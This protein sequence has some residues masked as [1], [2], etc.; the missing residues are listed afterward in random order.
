MANEQ[1]EFA[2]YHAPILSF[3]S[4]TLYRD[5]ARAWRGTGLLYLLFLLV[6]LWIPDM[7]R[8][9]VALNALAEEGAP[10]LL[11]QVPSF[12]ITKGVM[13]I[14]RP[15]PHTITDKQDKPVIIFDD[16]GKFTSLDGTEASILITGTQVHV[17]DQNRTN[18]RVL[19]LASVDGV[20]ITPQDIMDALIRVK[21]YGVLVMAPLVLFFSF[22]WRVFVGLLYSLLG[23]WVAGQAKLTL[24][25][26]SIFRLALVAM[27]PMMVVSTVQDAMGISM[28]WSTL[29]TVVVSS[30]Y[31]V[32]GIQ[33]CSNP[34]QEG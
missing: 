19:D 27:T 25:H 5:V 3:F 8:L 31:L 34:T 20:E 18:S 13:S 30:G 1:R 11:R 15:A 24:D 10:G 4:R 6:V 17:R 9:Q 28:P 32:F 33:S 23:I 22:W 12:R 26:A 29:V 7:V 14:D 16:T 2:Y 21:H